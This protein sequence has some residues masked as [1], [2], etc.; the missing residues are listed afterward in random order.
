[1][2]DGQGVVALDSGFQAVWPDFDG[3]ADFVAFDFVV[4]TATRIV[5]PHFGEN[6]FKTFVSSVRRRVVTE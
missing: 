4:P 5:A 3:Q 2:L 1:M 6:D